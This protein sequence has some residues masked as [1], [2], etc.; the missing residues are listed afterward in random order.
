MSGSRQTPGQSPTQSTEQSTGENPREEID[1]DEE[2]D[3]CV[4]GSSEG[5]DTSNPNCYLYDQYNYTPEQVAEIN[6]M[7]EEEEY[8]VCEPT[9]EGH[10]AKSSGR[11]KRRTR[12][13]SKRKRSKR[14]RS[15][16]KRSKRKR[17]K[18]K[19]SKRKRSRRN[20]QRKRNRTRRGGTRAS[21][22]RTRTRQLP[23]RGAYA[24]VAAA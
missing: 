10:L 16:R 7:F 11:K 19:R 13:R 3:G 5:H 23:V 20:R 14:K 17:S 15:K 12:K 21:L 4:T 9:G 1:P 22:K 18:R 2:C 8:G 6:R 24:A